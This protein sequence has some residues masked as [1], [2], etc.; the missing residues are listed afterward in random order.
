ME[1]NTGYIPVLPGA[2]TSMANTCPLCKTRKARRPCPAVGQ[3]ICPVCC[4]TKRQRE[5]ACPET[6]VYLASA[7]AHPPAVVQRRQERD[8]AFLLP[9]LTELS[10][11]QYRLLVLF[12]GLALR[13]WQ[14]AAGGDPLALGRPTLI[15]PDVADAANTMAATLETAGKGIIYHHQATSIPAQQ[16]VA[17]FETAMQELVANAG[18]HGAR[19]ERDAAA[20]LRQLARAASSAAQG[21]AGDETPIFL[22]MLSRMMTNPPQ[23]EDA[24]AD[25]P[26]APTSS[27]IIPG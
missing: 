27:L 3:Q 21:L 10:E 26:D 9:L 1:R 23:R 19:L 13:A 24:P 5:I 18:A 7:S 8:L 4:G 25:K 17:L 2:A 20:A 14:T 15:D 11:P 22:K 12:Q 6:C 16:L